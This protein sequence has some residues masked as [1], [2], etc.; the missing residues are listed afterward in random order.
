MTNTKPPKG[1]EKWPTGVEPHGKGLRIWFMYQNKRCREPL[2]QIAKVNLTSVRYAENKRQS[3]VVEIKEGHFSYIK[4]FPD[5][6]AAQLLCFGQSVNTGRTVNEGV[7]RWLEVQNAKKAASTARNY[8]HKSKHLTDHFHNLTKIKDIT[9]S[10]LEL[11]QAGLLKKRLSPKTVNDIFTVVRGVWEDAFYDHVIPLDICQRIKNIETDNQDSMADPFTREELHKIEVTV[12]D[13][14]QDKNMVLFNSWCGLSISEVMALA[15]ED[16]DLES[17][18]V[19]IRRARVESVYKV[20]KEKG[21]IRTVELIEPAKQ[22]LLAQKE[23]TLMLMPTI[24]QT[25]QRDNNTKREEVVNFV[26]MNTYFDAHRP[27]APYT[28][29]SAARWFKTLLQKSKVRYRGINQCRHTFASQ[30]LSCYVPLEWV[31]RQL[32]HNDTTMVKKHYSKWIPKDT[33]S[34]AAWV[35]E[36]MGFGGGQGGL[37]NTNFAPKMP[38]K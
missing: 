19:H 28:P 5:S 38:Q 11:F 34:M 20:P 26:F 15:W 2:K 29:A 7:T 18:L 13:R 31:S 12:T 37:E 9:K 1:I 27:P 25:I 21:R 33:K 35:S 30:A 23:H 8:K 17:G 16:V 36:S 24:I 22:W 3:I 32:G 6:E 14:A 4:H 10:D